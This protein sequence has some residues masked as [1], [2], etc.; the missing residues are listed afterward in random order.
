MA[1]ATGFSPAGI[2]ISHL[3][4]QRKENSIPAIQQR[5]QGVTSGQPGCAGVNN[6]NGG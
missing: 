2:S 3:M 5:R 6:W 1:W 4:L